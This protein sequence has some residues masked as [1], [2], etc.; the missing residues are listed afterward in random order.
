MLTIGGLHTS[1]NLVGIVLSGSSSDK[2]Y[3]QL[4]E[5]GEEKVHEGMLLLIHG[6]RREY[7][8]RVDNIYPRSTLYSPQSPLVMA[9]KKGMALNIID[10]MD[11]RYMIAEAVVLG[12][13]TDYGLRD[14]NYP[15]LPGDQVYLFDPEKDLKR[16]FGV[17]LGARG[18]VFIGSI[19]GY[20][21]MPLPLD[22]ENITMH[23]GIYGV[24]G[25]GKSYFGGI[26][27]EK[28]SNIPVSNNVVAALPAIVVDAN[29]DYLDY[30]YEYVEEG[31][32][33]KYKKV[34][35]MVFPTSK[36]IHEKY[37]PIYPSV[38]PIHITLDEFNSREIAELIITYKMGGVSQTT[39][40]QI[41]GL[42]R[43][44]DHVLEE[45]YSITEVL[46]NENLLH[47]VL[48]ESLKHLK[49]EKEIHPSTYN[50]II[51]AVKKFVS[52]LYK[53]Y[54]I[55]ST[56]PT[57]NNERID[58]IV[59]RPELVIIDF[60]SE[61]A[62]GIPLIVKQLVIGYLAKALY[63][64]FTY[65]KLRGEEKYLL[66]MIEEAQNYIPSKSYP[67][68]SSIARE[69]LSLI[70]TQGRKFGLC[71]GLITQRASFVDPIVVSMLNTHFIFRMSPEDTSY[72]MKLS[73]GLPEA[74]KRRITRLSRGTAIVMGQ[75]NKL[76]HPI[77]IETG[78]RTVSHR[79][80]KTD[81]TG[82]LEKLAKSKQ[83]K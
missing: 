63:N 68:G 11:N 56:K 22:I 45:N 25:S 57:I 8:I 59:N 16:V 58:K 48:I 33:G 20:E 65:Y 53:H 7:L 18:I 14:V 42:T 72:V 55:L 43:A 40:L 29:G 17:E 26:L 66:L 30:Y 77:I 24:T 49:E 19:L 46:I 28:L 12:Q 61:G 35:R 15:P 74:L 3:I 34:S 70:A 80:G 1:K 47:G 52:D 5:K 39:E 6:L 27:L 54:K 13:I 36:L 69:Y 81:L 4:T 41:A 82:F 75:M 32:F 67:I 9:Q 44:L 64:R 23:F 78:R 37:G 50:A 31:Y 51:S 62:P 60:T 21:N 73:G 38:E 83:S 2:V 71:L 79:M 10:K 76:G